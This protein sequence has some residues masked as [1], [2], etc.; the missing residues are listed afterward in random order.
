MIISDYVRNQPQRSFS[1]FNALG[2]YAY[3]FNH[4][5]FAWVDT[6]GDEFA[7]LPPCARQFHS[8]GGITPE[9]EKELGTILGELESHQTAGSGTA[10]FGASRSLPAGIKEL[11]NGL[12]VI[13]NDTHVSKWVEQ[14]GRLDHDQN[15][16]PFILPLIKEGDSVIDAGAFIGDHTIAYSKA[17]GEK[18]VVHAFEPNPIAYQCMH[19]NLESCRNVILHDVG[20][21]DANGS[22]PL[23][24]N[25]GNYAGAYA[26]EHMKI[27][28]VPVQ[29]LDDWFYQAHIDFIKFDIE[30]CEVKALIGAQNLI[31]R[32]H[33]TMVIEVNVVALDRQKATVGQL[34]ALLESYGYEW[35]I[36]QE[37]CDVMSPMYDIIC[38]YKATPESGKEVY[39]CSSEPPPVTPLTQASAIEFLQ[40]EAAK[41]KT[42]RWTVM[43]ALWKAGLTSRN[44]KKKKVKRVQVPTP[45]LPEKKVEAPS[46]TPKNKKQ[47]KVGLVSTKE[48]TL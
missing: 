39:R 14:Q 42:E 32:C 48:K 16:L 1:E 41:G 11:P 7:L 36:I 30:G 25:N 44:K 35:K 22:M 9:V 4:D 24:G 2:A 8:W 37:N 3:K 40:K 19:H 13:E 17:V 43:M 29:T 31:R 46:G 26:G 33:P 27:A 23:S 28:D 18:G 34:F 5:K 12:W 20:L 45:P 6:Q 21:S 47:H 10:G 15:T 38:S